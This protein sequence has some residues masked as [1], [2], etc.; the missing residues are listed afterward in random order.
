MQIDPKLLDEISQCELDPVQRAC[1]RTAGRGLGLLGVRPETESEQ[2]FART[3]QSIIDAFRSLLLCSALLND[4]S[5]NVAGYASDYHERLRTHLR[6]EPLLVAFRAALDSALPRGKLQKIEILRKCVQSVVDKSSNSLTFYSVV[7]GG[8]YAE[9][10]RVTKQIERLTISDIWNVARQSRRFGQRPSLPPALSAEDPLY[11][12]WEI[13]KTRLLRR[14]DTWHVWIN[15]FE[16]RMLGQI[17]DEVPSTLWKSVEDVLSQNTLFLTSTDPVEVNGIFASE[18]VEQVEKLVD[19]QAHHQVSNVA[20]AVTLDERGIHIE[21]QASI[22]VDQ[23]QRS[24][25][26]ELCTAVDTMKEEC[27]KTVL[28][29]Y[30]MISN[31]ILNHSLSKAGM[32]QYLLYFGATYKEEA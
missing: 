31:I 26:E 7:Q 32:I 3:E 11:R 5:P 14:S 15:W 2:S 20:P 18:L 4:L 25:I 27:K 16:F 24:A 28:P 29:S 23:L 9:R 19:F 30:V 22:D 12:A 6:W 8:S 17:S 10:L 21:D 1:F 13:T